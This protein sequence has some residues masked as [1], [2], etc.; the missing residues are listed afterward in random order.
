MALPLYNYYKR[1]HAYSILNI[2]SF[3]FYNHTFPGMS[4]KVLI[5]RIIIYK[6]SIGSLYTLVN[7]NTEYN[8]VYK[9]NIK[10]NKD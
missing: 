2:A 7:Y 6:E 3:I 1:L 9:V 4:I 10:A 5:W 8:I